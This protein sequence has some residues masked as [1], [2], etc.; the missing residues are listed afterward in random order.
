MSEE[1]IEMIMKK[2]DELLYKAKNSGKNQV[3]V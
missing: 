1:Q 3:R 2:A